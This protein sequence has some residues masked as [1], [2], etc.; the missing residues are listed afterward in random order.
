MAEQ[1]VKLSFWMNVM[2]LGY[3]AGM[4]VNLLFLPVFIYRINQ[5]RRKKTERLGVR[6]FDLFVFLGPLS[7]ADILSL[8]V[9][10]DGVP[11]HSLS[12]MFTIREYDKRRW[13]GITFSFFV[14]SNR[15]FKTDIILRQNQATHGFFVDS[16]P[17]IR[18][19]ISSTRYQNRSYQIKGIYPKQKSLNAQALQLFGVRKRQVNFTKK[20]KIL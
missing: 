8:L 6:K 15:A 11:T 1:N 4:V 16:P 10:A 7:C 18:N 2:N 17:V 9:W 20:A 19:G 12:S 13:I 14:P 5:A 3:G